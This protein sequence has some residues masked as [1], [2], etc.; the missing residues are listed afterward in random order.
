MPPFP[1]VYLRDGNETKIFVWHQGFRSCNRAP[2]CNACRFSLY[3]Q[4]IIVDGNSFDSSTVD[5]CWEA[6][7]LSKGV[8]KAVLFYVEQIATVHIVLF[9][10]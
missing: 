10:V 5:T 6:K 7:Q 2:R 8:N 1:K 9:Y 3:I 4:I